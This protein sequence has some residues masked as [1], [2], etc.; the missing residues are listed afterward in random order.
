[1]MMLFV[2]LNDHNNMEDHD[3]S[4]FIDLLRTVAESERSQKT[5]AN[6]L[7]TPTT[8]IIVF[9]CPADSSIGDLV[10]HSLTHSLSDLFKNTPTE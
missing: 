7:S 9:S 1:M 2:T 10:T 6:I 3:G 4:V 8:N 5:A